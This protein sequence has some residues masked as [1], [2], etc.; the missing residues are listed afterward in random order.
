MGDDC[1]VSL[2]PVG[3][4]EG[5]NNTLVDFAVEHLGMGM[6]VSCLCG[7]LATGRG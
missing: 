5:L 4:W 6:V 3:Y 7:L 1:F 2:W